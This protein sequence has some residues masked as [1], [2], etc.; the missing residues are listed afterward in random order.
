MV[1]LIEVLQFVFQVGTV[2]DGWKGRL[3]DRRPSSNGDPYKIASVIIT[4][5]KSAYT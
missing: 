5:T 3:E 2:E 1:F 4:T